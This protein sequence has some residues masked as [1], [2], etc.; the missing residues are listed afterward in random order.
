MSG[1]A[2]AVCYKRN[3]S[4]EFE[5]VRHMTDVLRHRGGKNTKIKNYDYGILG[6]TSFEACAD[7]RKNIPI[8]IKTDN[9]E[10]AI[11]FDGLIYNDYELRSELTKRGISCDNATDA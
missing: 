5:N 6:G 8:S 9:G 2:G 3:I 11:C 7:E 1:I 10:F 4:H